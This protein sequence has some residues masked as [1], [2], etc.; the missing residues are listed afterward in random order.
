MSYAKPKWKLLYAK[1]QWKLL[2]ELLQNDAGSCYRARLQ[3]ANIAW[4]PRGSDAT[5]RTATT[6]QNRG[7]EI[8]NF[9][10][11]YDTWRYG[12][13]VAMVPDRDFVVIRFANYNYNYEDGHWRQ[14]QM[15]QKRRKTAFIV[16]DACLYAATFF[17]G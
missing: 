3:L 15:R 12:V 10:Y 14:D 13:I 11:H 4:K 1:P 6:D 5:Q 16:D 7:H 17:P 8:G 2:Q 9:V